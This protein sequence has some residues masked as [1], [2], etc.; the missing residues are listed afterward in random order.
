VS[1]WEEVPAVTLSACI[2][3][4]LRWTGETHPWGQ[5]IIQ[6]ER[7]VTADHVWL[8]LVNLIGRER[9]DE[10][11]ITRLLQDGPGAQLTL[12]DLAGM[13]QMLGTLISDMQAEQA[14]E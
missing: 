6:V 9:G 1:G 14:A 5:G 10:R 13:H 7:A 3:R 11:K 8:M 12:A 2:P 4:A